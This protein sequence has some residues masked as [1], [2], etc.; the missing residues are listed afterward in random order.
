MEAEDFRVPILGN[1]GCLV[2]L[3]AAGRGCLVLGLLAGCVSGGWR[4]AVSFSEQ[5]QALFA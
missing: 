1:P 2:E 4:A 5:L 3:I